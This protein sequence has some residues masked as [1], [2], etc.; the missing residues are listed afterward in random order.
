MPHGKE[1]GI[2][3]RTK[4]ESPERM[5]DLLQHKLRLVIESDE[6]QEVK[7][8]RDCTAALKEMNALRKDLQPR[9]AEGAGTGVIILPEVEGT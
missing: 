6:T 8:L 9:D 7:A 4:T 1:R 5:L 2:I 3:A